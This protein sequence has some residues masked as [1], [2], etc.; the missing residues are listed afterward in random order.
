[1]T[2]L[3]YQPPVTNN[4]PKQQTIVMAKLETIEQADKWK[5]DAINNNREL[6]KGSWFFG[7]VRI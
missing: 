7:N 4:Q 2:T 1:M 5:R 6:R 3:Y